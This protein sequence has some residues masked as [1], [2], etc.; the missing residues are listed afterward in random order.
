MARAHGSY[1]WRQGFKS[2]SRYLQSLEMNVHLFQ[3]FFYFKS[4]A[5]HLRIH[6]ACI[7]IA[8]RNFKP[9]RNEVDY[10]SWHGI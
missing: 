8:W 3:D 1:P 9:F 4:K 6:Y 5:K 2:L 10:A 7:G